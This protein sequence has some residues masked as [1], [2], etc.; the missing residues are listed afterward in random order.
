MIKGERERERERERE[1]ERESEG[2][3]LTLKKWKVFADFF[4]QI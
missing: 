3:E 2:G 4:Q 1:S